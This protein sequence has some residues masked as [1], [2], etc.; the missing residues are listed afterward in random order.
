[1]RSPSSS[2]T[3]SSSVSY[4]MKCLDPA[5]P[6]KGVS[7]SSSNFPTNQPFF[8]VSFSTSSS[9]SSSSSSSSV[10]YPTP[11]YSV[12]LIAYEML[13]TGVTK[14]GV[15]SVGRGREWLRMMVMMMVETLE[16]W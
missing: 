13:S 4:H 1:M 9:A 6:S 16:G 3:S 8:F 15:R 12:N 14:Q 11:K 7:S 2:S 5:L 10:S